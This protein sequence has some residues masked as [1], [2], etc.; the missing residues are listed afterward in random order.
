LKAFDSRHDFSDFC[1]AFMFTYIDFHNDTA[2]LA[3]IGTLC[4]CLGRIF[5]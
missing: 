4:R 5:F 3:T 2:G 1:L